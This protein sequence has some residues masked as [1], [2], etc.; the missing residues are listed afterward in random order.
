MSPHR[1][2]GDKTPDEALSEKNP[3]VG[4]FRIFG[5]LTCSHVPSEKRTNIEHTIEKRIFVGYSETSK[6]F[7]IYIPS[8]RKKMV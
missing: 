4:N 6:A 2:L 8:L 7:C 1:V 3:N 5:F